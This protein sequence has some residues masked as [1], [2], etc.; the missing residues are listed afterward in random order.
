MEIKK[1]FAMWGMKGLVFDS[2]GNSTDSDQRNNC[3]QR[4]DSNGNFIS[5]WG[6]EGNQEGE[7][8]QLRAVVVVSE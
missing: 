3:I 6:R 4:F 8:F 5:S 2:F 7:F 1:P